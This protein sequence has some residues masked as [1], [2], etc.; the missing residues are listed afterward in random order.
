MSHVHGLRTSDRIPSANAQDG[1]QRAN[2]FFV[3]VN[4]RR[5]IAT[6]GETEYDLLAEAIRESRQKLHFLFLG[7]VLIPRS[8][9][10]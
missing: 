1:G 2:R 6:L 8:G 4:L 7:Y 10:R 9:T 5:A 3:T